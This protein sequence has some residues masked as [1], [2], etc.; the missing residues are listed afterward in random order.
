MSFISY[1]TLSNMWIRC[2]EFAAD[3][4]GSPPSCSCAQQNSHHAI[5]ITCR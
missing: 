3:M 4:T 2:F 1:Y 5:Y